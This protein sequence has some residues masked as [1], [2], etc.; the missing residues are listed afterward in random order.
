MRCSNLET[1]KEISLLPQT[2]RQG[3]G[4]QSAGKRG[5]F[6]AVKLKTHP[7]SV[8]RLGISGVIHLLPAHAFMGCYK[9]QPMDSITKQTNLFHTAGV[10][11]Q[12]GIIKV[13]ND[14]TT[15]YSDSHRYM[16]KEYRHVFVNKNMGNVQ[17]WV[18]RRQRTFEINIS[19]LRNNIALP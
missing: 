3:S 12:Y 5:S 16:I 11:T 14:R 6:P 9:I 4:A 15:A 1:P 2:F 7:Y 8:P 19:T 13:G 10:R 17:L 18:L